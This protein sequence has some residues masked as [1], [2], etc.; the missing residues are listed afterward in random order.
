MNF[1]PYAEPTIKASLLIVDGDFK[2]RNHLKFHRDALIAKRKT[3]ESDLRYSEIEMEKVA[4]QSLRGAYELGNKG[5]KSMVERG[6]VFGG[7]FF[8][9]SNLVF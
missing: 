1:L 4:V 8:Q 6:Y 7:R 2:N 9:L 3:K 5:L